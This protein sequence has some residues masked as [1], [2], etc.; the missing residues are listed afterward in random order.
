MHPLWGFLWEKKIILCLFKKKKFP[1][2]KGD[3]WGSDY[4]Q[5]DKR[6]NHCRKDMVDANRS[7]V[8]ETWT[9]VVWEDA[10]R[11]AE[12]SLYRGHMIW[13]ILCREWGVCPQTG[14]SEQDLLGNT[15]FEDVM[16]WR[17]WD[18]VLLGKGGPKPNSEGRRFS[19]L[20]VSSSL[21]PHG[22]SFTRLLCP[23]D[24]PGKHTGAG[25][26]AL[27]QGIFPTQGSNP[28]LLHWQ[29]G[30]LASEPAGTP[31]LSLKPPSLAR[32]HSN[33]LHVLPYNKRSW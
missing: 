10:S 14:A 9:L 25:C 5:L 4:C 22:L 1:Q 17:V 13:V 23:W 33:Q 3:I 29:A 20:V 30:S 15:V 12:R 31:A 19:C 21:P 8:S 7:G 11:Q 24:S 27:L 18:E 16:R 26:H 6:R 2:G 32:R 28:H